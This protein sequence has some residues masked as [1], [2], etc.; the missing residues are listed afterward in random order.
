MFTDTCRD[1]GFVTMS[2]HIDIVWWP[3]IVHAGVAGGYSGCGEE[4]QMSTAAE[5]T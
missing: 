1:C 5:G 2:A 3:L 4:W